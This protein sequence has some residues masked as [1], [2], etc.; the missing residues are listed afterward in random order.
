MGRTDDLCPHRFHMGR[1]GKRKK[2][3]RTNGKNKIT[4]SAQ[5]G[6]RPN[7]QIKQNHRH[8]ND[9]KPLGPI[10][11]LFAAGY[12][13]TA[14]F[15][16]DQRPFADCHHNKQKRKQ[17]LKAE[18]QYRQQQSPPKTANFYIAPQSPSFLFPC[19]VFI[20]QPIKTICNIRGD[21]ADNYPITFFPFPPPFF[22]VNW[23]PYH[24]M[25]PAN[26]HPTPT[27]EIFLCFGL[28]L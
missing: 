18:P 28:D 2:K 10:S 16:T 27:P 3:R 21:C 6:N 7:D 14:H 19:K 24:L 26:Q 9:V 17:K 13:K 5:S 1:I 23:Q 20:K 12:R 25:H 8:H 4:F 15:P 22:P 11:Q